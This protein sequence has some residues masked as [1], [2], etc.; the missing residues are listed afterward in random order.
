MGN[1]GTL[2]LTWV[3]LKLKKAIPCVR[4]ILKTSTRLYLSFSGYVFNH[5]VMIWANWGKTPRSVHYDFGQ[6][7]IKSFFPKKPL[8]SNGQTL[9]VTTW[10]KIDKT[11]LFNKISKLCF[12][13]TASHPKSW[14]TKLKWANKKLN[15]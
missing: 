10:K 5:V 8:K 6:E 11:T 9:V 1:S 7:D 3:A 13:R 15:E 12:F 2:S 14:Q 4:Q